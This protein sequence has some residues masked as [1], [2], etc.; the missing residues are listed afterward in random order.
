[1]KNFKLLCLHIIVDENNILIR[2]TSEICRYF[3]FFMTSK[4]Y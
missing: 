2:P 3:I 1:M 4:K